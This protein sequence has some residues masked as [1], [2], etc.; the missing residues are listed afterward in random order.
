MQNQPIPTFYENEIDLRIYI[1][2]L[3]RNWYW[4]LIPA[5]LI[6]GIAFLYISSQPA[7]YKTTALVSVSAPILDVVFDDRIVTD[8][9][10]TSS[11]NN[12]LPN[13]AKS[14]EILFDLFTQ[15]EDTL[16]SSIATYTDLGA[17]LEASTET[18]SGIVTLS[19]TFE[20]PILSALVVN[21]WSQ[22]FIVKAN[23]FFEGSIENSQSFLE[24]QLTEAERE[25]NDIN[26]QWTAFQAQNESARITAELESQKSLQE[27]Y[28]NRRNNLE[29]LQYDIQGIKAQIDQDP[30][31]ENVLTDLTL[32]SLQNRA[33]DTSGNIQLEITSFNELSTST[34][35]ERVAQLTN[36]E[37]ATNS[38]L[39]ELTGRIEAIEPSIFSLQEQL[40]ILGI[41]RA[42]L[43]TSRNIILSTYDTLARKVAEGE[44]EQ[45]DTSGKAQIASKAI[46]PVDAQPR[47]SVIA[48]TIS[49]L[50]TAMI[51]ILIILALT[52][53]KE[54][55]AE[56]IQETSTISTSSATD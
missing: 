45:N 20:D 41:E 29:L 49:I 17:K 10:G 40:S 11:Q 25:R 32:Y 53:W 55:E 34:L 3:L 12:D 7:T 38:Q 50:A 46:V 27:A 51:C 42:K 6:G 26:T 44:I 18:R 21:E 52:W 33:F 13:L 54:Q 36:L 4:I 28:I 16:P 35:E 31:D 47:G 1:R 14:D 48:S 9:N 56:E 24:S 5:I 37:I 15:L 19:G 8:S 23:Q 43:E 39:A 2:A 22:I 30:N